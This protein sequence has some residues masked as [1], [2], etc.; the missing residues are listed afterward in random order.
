MVTDLD[1]MLKVRTENSKLPR[2]E[3][4]KRVAKELNL[5]IRSVSGRVTRA[6]QTIQGRSILAKWQQEQAGKLDKAE[7]EIHAIVNEQINELSL[8]RGKLQVDHPYYAVFMSD[9]HYPYHDVKALELAYTIIDD[10]KDVAYISVLSDGFDLSTLSRFPDGRQAK[11]RAL[12][13]DLRGT[14]DLYTYHLDT[15]KLIAPDALMLPVVGNHDL[16]LITNNTGIENYLQLEVIKQL[17]NHNVTMVTDFNRENIIKINNG[18]Y[19]HHGRYARK[20]RQNGAKA[21]YEYVKQELQSIT[22]FTLVFGHI[23]DSS[24]WQDVHAKSYGAG[25]LCQL[26]P[27]YTRHNQ[28]WQHGIVI[29]QFDRQNWN[30]TYNIKFDMIGDK[31]KAFNPFTGKSY[32][33]NIQC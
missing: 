33:I 14:L 5:S 21:N 22:D 4:V 28:R 23:H 2:S 17:V 3:A 1:L 11:D 16:R 26:Q 29:S 20:N 27:H 25:C 15:L 9:T 18:L 31:I 24:Y 13:S 32:E 8:Y 7:I 30:L 6:E 19:W 10:L 12:D